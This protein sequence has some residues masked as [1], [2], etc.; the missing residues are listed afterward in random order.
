MASRHATRIGPAARIVSAEA[1]TG[2]RRAPSNSER[3]FTALVLLLLVW[4]LWSYVRGGI[5]HA[6]IAAALDG[7]RSL[8][9]IRAAVERA[10]HLGPV[11]YVAAVVVEVLIAPIPGT[12]LYAPGGALFGGLFGGALSLAGN[13][14]GAAVAT[15][16]A[17]TFRARLAGRLDPPQLQRLAERVGS[18]GLLVV[19][20]L[21]LNP[22][23]SS[24]LVSYAAGLAG[25]PVW[26]VA[27]GTAIG[28]APLCFAQAYASEWIFRM[29]PGSGLVVLV[30]GIAYVGVIIWIVM[31]LPA[32]KS[33]TPNHP[34]T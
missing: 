29:L 20:L 3:I 32:G 2:R 11:V 10:G 24:D 30:C 27:L 9:A 23:T 19:T 7:G 5:V 8:D 17:R 31:R 33:S 6:L 4:A 12:L 22:L 26:R 13:T 34:G 25:I 1:A 14:I 18:R 21:R 15:W 16:L 28:M